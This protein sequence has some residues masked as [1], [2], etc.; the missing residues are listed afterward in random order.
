MACGEL[1]QAKLSTLRQLYLAE[2][3]ALNANKEGGDEMSRKLSEGAEIVLEGILTG[4]LPLETAEVAQDTIHSGAQAVFAE[5]K[6]R[7]MIDSEEE[8]ERFKEGWKKAA[9][10]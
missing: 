1:S 8:L 10:E 3:M 5:V 6:I 4:N 9:D 2:K 7:K